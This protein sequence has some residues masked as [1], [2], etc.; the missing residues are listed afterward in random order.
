[1]P[2]WTKLP[3]CTEP[4]FGCLNCG[5]GEMRRDGERILANMRTRLY[6]PECVIRRDDALWFSP[7]Y[8]DGVAWAD[9]PTLMSIEHKA[10][11]EPNHDWRFAFRAALRDATYQRQGRNEWVLVES[12]DGYA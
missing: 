11:N 9:N 6:G 2:K 1:M 5:G 10:R 7:A 3:P 4:H 12:G 8:G